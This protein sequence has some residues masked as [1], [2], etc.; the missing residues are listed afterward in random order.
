MLYCV[1]VINKQQN[2]VQMFVYRDGLAR[3]KCLYFKVVRF[4]LPSKS[5]FATWLLGNVD[6]QSKSIYINIWT[7]FFFFFFFFDTGRDNTPRLDTYPLQS[8]SSYI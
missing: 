8:K 2:T 6:L 5:C 1:L 7:I 4:P 3:L